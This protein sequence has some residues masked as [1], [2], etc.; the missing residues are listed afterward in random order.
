MWSLENFSTGS[1]N[2]FFVPVVVISVLKSPNFWFVKS[3]DFSRINASFSVVNVT[4][5]V[6]WVST[7]SGSIIWIK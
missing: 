5:S 7:V 6:N 1:N 3:V 2:K 4:N